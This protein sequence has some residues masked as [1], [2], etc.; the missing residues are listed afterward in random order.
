MTIIT[1]TEDNG[2]FG[3]ELDICLVFILSDYSGDTP[4]I[5]LAYKLDRGS[6]VM[7]IHAQ[8]FRCGQQGIGHSNSWPAAVHT[9]GHLFGCACGRFQNKGKG[10]EG[11]Q[12]RNRSNQFFLC[13]NMF[14]RAAGLLSHIQQPVIDMTALVSEYLDNL[15]VCTVRTIAHKLTGDKF[16]VNL[17]AY[18]LLG[19]GIYRTVVIAAEVDILGLFNQG[20]FCAVLGSSAGCAQ[21]GHTGT[22]D[23]DICVCSL[24]YLAV[25]DRFG[26]F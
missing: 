23:D 7:N 19:F 14:Y 1:G 18:A 2:F 10:R 9:L 20:N 16:R 17:G 13:P 12:G 11:G 5:V 21:A 8:I 3:I 24:A 25:C 26:C 4:L 15:L 6:F 22:D